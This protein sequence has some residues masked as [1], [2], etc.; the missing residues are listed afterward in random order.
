MNDPIP[1][2]AAT[3]DEVKDYASCK[4]AGGRCYGNMCVIDGETFKK[5]G[6]ADTSIKATAAAETFTSATMTTDGTKAGTKITVNGKEVANLTSFCMSFWKNSYGPPISVSYS[7]S[8]DAEA[9]EISSVTYFRMEPPE[10]DGANAS[11]AQASKP[12]FTIQSSD[13]MPIELQPHNQARRELFGQ[14]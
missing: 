7:T 11:K 12:V 2:Q 10:A 3:T 4:A 1:A 5:A 6:Q 13:V 8:E 9:G 14:I